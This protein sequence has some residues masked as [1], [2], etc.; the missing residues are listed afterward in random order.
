MPNVK[1]DK[2]ETVDPST[3]V[4]EDGEWA[5]LTTWEGR[6]VVINMDYPYHALSERQEILNMRQAEHLQRS[7]V[8]V[9][10]YRGKQLRDG[11][12]SSQVTPPENLV[13]GDRFWGLVVVATNEEE[14]RRLMKLEDDNTNSL[15]ENEKLAKLHE[16]WRDLDNQRKQNSDIARA[17]KEEKV[18]F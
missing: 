8:N 12:N 2:E 11:E 17:K 10:T 1:S 14:N 16:K 6:K 18:R 3:M 4:A 5:G 7:T 15:R 13:T 9:R